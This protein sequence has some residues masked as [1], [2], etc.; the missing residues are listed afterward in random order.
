[1]PIFAL[2]KRL[3]TSA[4]LPTRGSLNSQ[5]GPFSLVFHDHPGPPTEQYIIYNL[6]IKF[7]NLVKNKL[8]PG[9][10]MEQLRRPVPDLQLPIRLNGL[11]EV[12]FLFFNVNIPLFEKTLRW[13]LP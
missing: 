5:P 1:M 9:P 12:G 7:V 2:A 4:T 6:Q 3:P 13:S 11:T 10:L 8:C